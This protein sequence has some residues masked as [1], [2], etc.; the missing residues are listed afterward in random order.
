V[1]N[2]EWLTR[3]IFSTIFFMDHHRCATP[4]P[5]PY[6]VLLEAVM[7]E[8]LRSFLIDTQVTLRE[9]AYIRAMAAAITRE[10]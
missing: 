7:G 1:T 4:P 2:P 9:I 5:K 10:Q 6:L 8:V 3:K